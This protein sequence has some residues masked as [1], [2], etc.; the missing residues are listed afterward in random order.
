MQYYLT[1]K[2]IIRKDDGSILI[3]KRSSTDDH[4][5]NI[6][7]NVGGGMDNEET[8]QEALAREV[9][10]ETGATLSRCSIVEKHQI[11]ISVIKKTYIW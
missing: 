3:V 4:K 10:E 6:W 5:P 8:P 1:V 2:A 9:L 7:E 11:H